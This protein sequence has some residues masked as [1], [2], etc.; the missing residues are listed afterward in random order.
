SPCC[1]LFEV[2]VGPGRCGM[3]ISA[4]LNPI[5]AVEE[6]RIPTR[7]HAMAAVED[8]EHLTDINELSL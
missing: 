2:E 5:A 4:G 1:P 3:V 6:A 7:S 8:F